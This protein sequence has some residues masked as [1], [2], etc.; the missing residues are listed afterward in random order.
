MGIVM[1]GNGLDAAV[2]AALKQPQQ[3]TGTV[4]RTVILMNPGVKIVFILQPAGLYLGT[5][6]ADSMS[7]DALKAMAA[8]FMAFA[9]EQAGG[10]QV[11]SGLPQG[12]AKAP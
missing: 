2:S 12:I 4:Q 7:M 3:V 1:T 5:I 11:A 6:T 10:V 8:D 9:T